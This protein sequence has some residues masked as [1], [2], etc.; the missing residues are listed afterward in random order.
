MKTGH[1]N[2]KSL[3]LWVLL[4]GMVLPGCTEILYYIHRQSVETADHEAE[5]KKAVEAE[6]NEQSRSP[7]K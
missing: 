4:A 3:L 5:R 7:Q 6:K 2:F 1:F